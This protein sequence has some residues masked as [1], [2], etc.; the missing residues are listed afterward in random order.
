[1]YICKAAVLQ[2][3]LDLNDQYAPTLAKL[4]SNASFETAALVEDGSSAAVHIF[5]AYFDSL[6]G[7]QIRYEVSNSTA[8]CGSKAAAR[9]A[10]AEAVQR[11]SD[12]ALAVIMHSKDLA[13]P[14]EMGISAGSADP[15][16][17]GG[18]IKVVTWAIATSAVIG[19]GAAEVL[20]GLCTA[21]CCV[22]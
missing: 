18:G 17:E 10:I 3:V 12:E 21:A 1:M 5:T 2:F 6:L 22:C 13:P 14:P 15:G 4:Q 7:P 19:V 16:D 8:Y 9:A 20:L 11:S